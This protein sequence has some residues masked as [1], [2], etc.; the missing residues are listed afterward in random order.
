MTINLNDIEKR[1]VTDKL[2][3][4]FLSCPLINEKSP[5]SA[6]YIGDEIQTYSIDGSPSETIIKTYIDGSTERQLI[7]DFTSRESVEAYN[8]EKNIS[9]YEK[10][11]EWVEI[12]NIQGNLPQLNYPLIPEK[13]EVLT[14]GYV[15]QMSANKAIY[16]IQMKFIYTKMAE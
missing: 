9:F 11:A 16:V 7:F 3:D 2:I 6:D 15:E 14:H 8:N 1:T 13:I 12:Q 10:L 4:F 5:I